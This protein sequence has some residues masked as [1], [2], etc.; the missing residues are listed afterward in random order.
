VT[1]P[2]EWLRQATSEHYNAIR[3]YARVSPQLSQRY[4][5]AVGDT[6]RAIANSPFI[7]PIVHKR[8]RRAGVR[9][10]PY[11]LFYRVEDKR[12]V[13]IA[14]FHGKRD[15]HRWQSREG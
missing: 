3:W 5:D 7:Y 14:C 13:V 6:V 2:V 15:P 12:I 9:P 10:F 1:L 11:G 4:T 8:L